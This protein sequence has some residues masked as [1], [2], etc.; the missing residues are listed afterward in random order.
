MRYIAA[1]IVVGNREIWNI[2]WQYISGRKA[3]KKQ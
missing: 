2:G 1:G 3:S